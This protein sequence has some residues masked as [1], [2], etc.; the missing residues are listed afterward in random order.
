MATLHGMRQHAAQVYGLLDGLAGQHPNAPQV[1][2]TAA[3]LEALLPDGLATHV[4]GTS[5]HGLADA[6]YEDPDPAQ[7]AAVRRALEFFKQR[8]EDPA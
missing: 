1:P 2:R 7:A 4:P 5:T 6:L 3:A 8:Q